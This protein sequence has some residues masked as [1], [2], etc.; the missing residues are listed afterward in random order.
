MRYASGVAFVFLLVLGICLSTGCSDKSTGPGGTTPTPTEL[1]HKWSHIFG[2]AF[3]Q[4]SYDVACDASGNI[5]IAGYFE[6]AVDFGG[7]TLTSAGAYDAFVAKFS[8]EGTHLW[9]DSF[10]DSQEQYSFGVAADN[11]G[12][13]II[14]GFF[15]GSVDFGSGVLTSAGL[16]DI[17]IAKFGL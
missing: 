11:S 17:F 10:G 1:E 9:S 3:E 14:T 7:G 8:P 4:F 12:D 15:A 2:D 5:I 6:G 13:V 16:Y